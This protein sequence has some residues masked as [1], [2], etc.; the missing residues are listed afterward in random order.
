DH[1]LRIVK[2]H[3]D[4]RQ[5]RIGWW[6]K[7]GLN[8]LYQVKLVVA[9]R[10]LDGWPGDPL[11]WRNF[12]VARVDEVPTSRVW[13]NLDERG[14]AS[15]NVEPMPAVFTIQQNAV[16]CLLRHRWSHLAE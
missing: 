1:R 5:L 7:G 14:G 16:G 9:G 6:A 13:A 10:S 12:A 15:P 3:G 8:L 4:C 2:V 11:H